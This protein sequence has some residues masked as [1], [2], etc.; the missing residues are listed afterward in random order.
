MHRFVRSPLS[1]NNPLRGIALMYDI[2]DASILFFAAWCLLMWDVDKQSSTLLY[3]SAVNEYTV[4]Q[5]EE[6]K[7]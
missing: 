7:K 2:L 5:L 1:V 4:A 6:E 3:R